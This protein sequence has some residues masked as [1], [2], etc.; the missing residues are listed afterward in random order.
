MVEFLQLVWLVQLA[1]KAQQTEVDNLNVRMEDV[2][3]SAD[4]DPN[5]DQEVVDARDGQATLGSNIRNVKD[6]LSIIKRANVYYKNLVDNGDFT[7][8]TTNWSGGVSTI[9]VANST[10]SMTGTGVG[11]DPHIRQDISEMKSGNKIYIRAKLKAITV[12]G[13]AFSFRLV[14]STSPS[15]T[16]KDYPEVNTEY[17]LSGVIQCPSD[18]TVRLDLRHIHSSASSAD[19]KT[20]EVREV[21]VI[22]LTESFGL[23]NEPSVA[24]MDEKINSI[25]GWFDATY[26]M[27]QKDLDDRL[28]A[29]ETIDIEENHNFIRQT[30]LANNVSNLSYKPKPM[31]VISY[32]DSP[33][34]DYTKAFPIHEQYGVPAEVCVNNWRL[35]TSEG[36][37]TAQLIE[38]Q[39][40]G[41]EIIS[42]GFNHLDFGVSF[43]VTSQ[44]VGDTQLRVDRISGFDY[45]YPFE[46]FLFHTDA[47][48]YAGL[49]EEIVTITGKTT[50]TEGNEVFVLSDPLQY[51]YTNHACLRLSDNQ[52]KIEVDD[53]IDELVGMG[54][55][56]K[57]F[58]YPHNSSCPY[59]RDYISKRLA[60]ARNGDALRYPSDDNFFIPKMRIPSIGELSLRP[61]TEIDSILD[62]I[63]ANNLMGFTYEHTWQTAFTSSKLE[64]LISKAIEKGIKITTRTEAM[65]HFGNVYELG[66]PEGGTIYR[67][68][69]FLDQPYIVV[70]KFGKVIATDNTDKQIA[71]HLKDYFNY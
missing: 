54:L 7:E 32:D 67:E 2:I 45:I 26:I 56:V 24:E 60:S 17:D 9:S 34:E 20:T 21:M 59:S 58:A 65:K 1:E 71:T 31:L 10:I 53:S 22:D 49:R 5:K 28:K 15:V 52:L 41:W 4:L 66:D 70:N 61:Q 50:D 3:Q 68:G 19:G 14:G 36:L 62:D 30:A 64:Y 57:G 29:V 44:D 11:S 8:G 27:S 23:G 55:E 25:G 39:D 40:A 13:V 48:S 37:T 35:N 38:M 63:V 16:V 42:H 43:V 51:S 47:S 12:S 46:G 6:E 33:P 69:W 18:G